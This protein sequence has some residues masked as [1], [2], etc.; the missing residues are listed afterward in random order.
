MKVIADVSSILNVVTEDIHRSSLSESLS[1][2]AKFLFIPSWAS[3][4]QGTCDA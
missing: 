1:K 2:L 3:G 4:H